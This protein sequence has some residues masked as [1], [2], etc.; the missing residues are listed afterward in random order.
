M[1]RCACCYVCRD[2]ERGL[3]SRSPTRAQSAVFSIDALDANSARIRRLTLVTWAPGVRHS[4]FRIKPDKVTGRRLRM[5][6][7]AL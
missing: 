6:P 4:W 2:G 3:A 7:D 5:V 1:S